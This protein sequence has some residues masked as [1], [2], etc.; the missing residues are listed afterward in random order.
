MDKL[1]L[2]KHNSL[3]LWCLSNILLALKGVWNL[4]HWY[5]TGWIHTFMLFVWNYVWLLQYQTWQHFVVSLCDS[6][7]CL[8]AWC[9]LLMLGGVS[10]HASSSSR[11]H[12]CKDALWWDFVAT[13]PRLTDNLCFA[14][15]SSSSGRLLSPLGSACLLC[16]LLFPLCC[17]LQT[18]SLNEWTGLK[19]PLCSTWALKGL[20]VTC[21]IRPSFLSNIHAHWTCPVHQRATWAWYIWRANQSSC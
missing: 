14:G 12:I 4:Y 8:A 5:Q 2:E 6:F 20:Y 9:V 11:V 3:R 18:S 13:L 15:W 21:L 10:L 1:S 16:S 17:S 19:W 7:L